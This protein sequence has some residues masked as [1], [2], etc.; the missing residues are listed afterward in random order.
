MSNI[1]SIR[2]LCLSVVFSLVMS[3]SF[4]SIEPSRAAETEPQES[5]RHPDWLYAQDIEVLLSG[6]TITALSKSGSSRWWTLYLEDGVLSWV[7][8][9]GRKTYGVWY[10]AQ[11]RL[12]EVWLSSQENC[13]GIRTT[14]KAVRY[15]DPFTGRPYSS[16][17]RVARRPHQSGAANSHAVASSASSRHRHDGCVRN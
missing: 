4:Q 10:I 6:N 2:W 5:P 11:D 13:W 17:T 15:D 16:R 14:G 8:D 12:C 7:N 1:M 9:R 3:L